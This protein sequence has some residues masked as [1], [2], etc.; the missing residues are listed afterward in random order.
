[1]NVTTI[2]KRVKDHAN[3]A[4]GFIKKK[5]RRNASYH[6]SIA[7]QYIADIDDKKERRNEYSALAV[8]KHE[9]GVH[10]NGVS[11]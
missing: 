1:M 11:P 5:D 10:E 7:A 4:L 3:E 2:T 9:N 6:F 8:L